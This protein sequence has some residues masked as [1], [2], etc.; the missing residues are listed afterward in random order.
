MIDTEGGILTKKIGEHFLQSP[1][2][3][4]LTKLQPDSRK[5]SQHQWM[6]RGPGVVTLRGEKRDYPAGNYFVKEVS[7]DETMVLN[8]EDS[9]EVKVESVQ[10]MKY[11]MLKRKGV[12]V[13]TTFRIYEEGG[14]RYTVATDLSHDGERFVWSTNDEKSIPQKIIDGI[15]W[16]ELATDLLNNAAKITQANIWSTHD[17]YVLTVGN[18]HTSAFVA[19]LDKEAVLLYGSEMPVVSKLSLRAV[20][21]VQAY[22][23]FL[24]LSKK[25]YGKDSPLIREKAKLYFSEVKKRFPNDPEIKNELLNKSLLQLTGDLSADV[26][27]EVFAVKPK[28]VRH[29]SKDSSNDRVHMKLGGK[30][31][32]VSLKEAS[33]ILHEADPLGASF[34]FVS[35]TEQRT[36]ELYRELKPGEI[37]EKE[38]TRN[39]KGENHQLG[40]FHV[41][42]CKAIVMTENRP[43]QAESSDSR[44]NTLGHSLLQ[45][46]YLRD[47]ITTM[48]REFSDS[49][50]YLILTS[51]PHTYI[52]NRKT[53]NKAALVP[54]EEFLR[55]AHPEINNGNSM[56]IVNPL[57]EYLSIRVEP[58]GYIRAEIDKDRVDPRGPFLEEDIQRNLQ[59]IQT[60]LNDFN[61][62]G[63]VG[64]T[65]WK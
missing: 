11:E 9:R 38:Y 14:K 3:V 42:E 35:P 22:R 63:I 27:H 54:I 4:D 65:D 8:G 1:T 16:D 47:A 17:A 59:E 19:A 13:P 40:T 18:G 12:R 10:L 64:Q 36:I 21:F 26:V 37:A 60:K 15:N 25:C 45:A 6:K 33:A 48:Q 62:M 23:T 39:P 32:T 30:N 53:P 41:R 50:K 52:E 2:R 56:V 46:Q 28:K 61:N 31:T 44:E 43:V 7:G 49:P 55:I 20:N 57:I 51:L 29:E 5:S 24:E 58:N 34:D